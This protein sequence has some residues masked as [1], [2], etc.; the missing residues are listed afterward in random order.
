MDTITRTEQEVR[1]GDIADQAKLAAEVL[2]PLHPDEEKRAQGVRLRLGV[3]QR[4]EH[5]Y[6][7]PVP[8]EGP[9]AWTLCSG[10]PFSDLDW[11]KLNKLDEHRVVGYQ[12]PGVSTLL[13]W[14]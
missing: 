3:T 4:G 2:T 10:R 11:A 14:E 1:G 9:S 7:E 6:Y 12:G 13:Y 8:G 5:R